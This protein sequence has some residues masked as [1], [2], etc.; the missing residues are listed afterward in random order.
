MDADPAA[1]ITIGSGLAM[2]GTGDDVVIDRSN[3]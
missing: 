1:P 2:D 3:G